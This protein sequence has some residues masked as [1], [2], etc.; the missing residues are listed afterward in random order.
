MME[1]LQM[2]KYGFYVW[3]CFGLTLSVLIFNEW[4]AR[5]RQRQMFRDVQVRVKATEERR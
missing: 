4:R 3:T 1:A 5:Q 2:G